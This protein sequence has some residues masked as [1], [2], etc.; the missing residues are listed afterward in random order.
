MIELIRNRVARRLVSRIVVAI[1][2]AAPLT[3]LASGGGSIMQHAGNDVSDVASLQRGARNFMNYC[4]GCHSAKYIRFSKMQEDLQLTE[5]QITENL[6]FAA[7]KTD[8]LMEI[9]M[10]PADAAR[11][12]GQAPPDLTL[13][14]RSR[15]TDWVYSFLK[16]FYLD[17]E[18]MTG[19]N[20][21]MLPNASMPAVLWELQGLQEATFRETTD[22]AGKPVSHFGDPAYFEHFEP[23]SAGTLSEEEFD[24]FVRDTVNFLDWAG[25][26]E[27]LKRQR[28]GIWVIIFLVVFLIF[29]YLLKVEIWKDVK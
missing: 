5:E 26:P 2:C 20:N 8:E 13:V 4:S 15:G 21:L 18:A 28:L 6:M 22:D 7:K 9:A 16:S 3:V 27:Q 23:V 25:T 24:Q 12:F 17:E 11:W 10:P 1:L 29:A 19:T 14:A